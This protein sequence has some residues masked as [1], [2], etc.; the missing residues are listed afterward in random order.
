MTSL[1]L[2]TTD[3]PPEDMTEAEG[4]SV[5]ELRAA[6]LK[7]QGREEPLPEQATHFRRAILLR[8]LR[9]RRSVKDP[10]NSSVKMFIEMIEW[11]YVS[12]G[13]EEKVLAWQADQTAEAKL[14][15][16]FWPCGTFGNDKRGQPVFYARYGTADVAGL[17]RE[18][19]F[20]H[21]IQHACFQQYTSEAMLNEVADAK[22]EHGVKFV[23]ILD[24]KGL[25]WGRAT[26]SIT[27]F[28]KMFAMLDANF[29][30]RLFVCL[31]VRAPWIF[32][33]IYKL[34]SPV[35]DANTRDKI[36][37]LG[38]SA[39]HM[40]KI[41]EF[42]DPAEVPD[43]LGGTAMDCEIPAG[44]TVPNSKKKGGEGEETAA[45]AAPRE[46]GFMSVCV[47]AG[48]IED[49]EFPDV[50]AGS[51]VSFTAKV[52]AYDVDFSVVFVETESGAEKVLAEKT[53]LTAELG[54]VKGEVAVEVAGVVRLRFDNTYSWARSK[55][56]LFKVA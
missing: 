3:H 39:D 46:D 40:A 10:L 35:L 51:K 52:E 41:S 38:G 31:V 22:G 43:W 17:V 37:I 21:F 32:S 53:R 34:V 16:R 27:S 48:T 12:Y 9:A 20:D 50:A 42:V 29:P 36:Q 49:T 54:E 5:E 14:V 23:C 18:T 24:L 55:T 45:A 28:N 8:F 25:K 30:E 4:K 2:S 6:I 19:S 7:A 1:N 13:F 47:A 11:Y 26:R 56:A 15:R 44:G 33:A